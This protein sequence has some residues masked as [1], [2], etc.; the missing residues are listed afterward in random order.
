MSP[1]GKI[2]SSCLEI[3]LFLAILDAFWWTL[4][5]YGDSWLVPWHD[6]VVIVRLAQNL[7]EGKG[8]R[9]D[10]IDN[11]LTG[12]DERTYWQMP[13]YPFVLSLWGKLFG[14]DLDSVRSFSRVIGLVSLF[15]LFHLGRSLNL[16]SAA[17]L[18][19][20]LWTATDLTFQFSANFARPEAVTGCLLLL[21]VVLLT[22]QPQLNLAKSMLAGLVSGFAVFSHPIAFP[23]WLVTASVIVKRSGWRNGFWFSLPFLLFASIWLVYVLQGWEIFLAQIRAHFA[24]KHYPITD[25]LAFLLGSTAWGIQF[26]IGV[27]LNTIPWFIPIVMTAWVGL[28]EKWLLPKWL[29]VFATILYA[30]AMIGAE[31]WYPPLFV[32]FG[33]LMLASFANHLLQKSSTKLGRVVLVAAVLSWWLCQVWVVKQ[34]LSAVPTIQEQ[35]ANFVADLERLLP[36]RATV[37]IGSFSPDPTFA[38]MKRRPDLKIYTLMPSQMLNVEALKQLRSHHL[39]HILVLEE[40]LVEPLLRGK[41]IKRWQFDFGGLANRQ[42]EKTIVLLTTREATQ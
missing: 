29:F 27:P 37:L 12:A 26:Y 31:A 13:L 2:S 24:H 3:L 25:R 42:G 10:L 8:F 30:A 23:C 11:L 33:Y 6:E 9:N 5:A 38:L 15:L 39:T 14:F 40:A 32:P 21:T 36:S 1:K 35:V 34:H 22:S 18:L 4:F 28:R 16:P 41:E 7:A 17:V 19:S 20:I